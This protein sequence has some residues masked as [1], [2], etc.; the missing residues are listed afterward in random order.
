MKY[1]LTK[2]EQESVINF[3]NELDTDSIYTL[4]SRLIKNLR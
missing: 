4:D 1:K 3:V 2:A